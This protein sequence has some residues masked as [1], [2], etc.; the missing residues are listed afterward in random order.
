MA[1]P[2]GNKQVGQI[3]LQV[4]YSAKLGTAYVTCNNFMSVPVVKDTTAPSTISLPKN[5]MIGQIGAVVTSSVKPATSVVAAATFLAVAVVRYAPPTSVLGHTML[6]LSVLKDTEAASA[7][8]VKLL[9]AG[10]GQVALTVTHSLDPN[11]KL[12][13]LH[14][15][16]AI[17][18]VR[19]FNPRR[20]HITLNI[21]YAATAKLNTGD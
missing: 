13:W 16:V 6:A 7:Q 20:E 19:K 18:V 1:V 2:P 9:N 17:V 11:L 14:Q 8:P 21:E 15:F 5:A 4:T 3:M 10:I 12:L